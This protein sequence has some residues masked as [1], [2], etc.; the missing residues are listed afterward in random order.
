MELWLITVIIFAC[1]ITFLLLGLPIAFTLSGIGIIFML[2]MKGPAG[3]LMVSSFLYNQGTSFILIAVPL[4]ILMANFLEV[5]DIADD[6]YN[7]MYRWSVRIPGGLASG[8]VIICAIFAAMA[9]ISGVATITM[10]LIAIPSMLK[11]NY[12]KR[13]VT[14]TVAAGGALGILIPPSVIAVLYGSIASASVGKLFMGG[15]I[16]GILL[17]VIF[18]LYITIR[19]IIQPELGPPT[20]ERFTW[21]EK[22][23]SLKAIILPLLMIFTVLST[24]YLGV[25]TPTEAAGIGALGSMVCLIVYRKFTW[26]N[27]RTALLRTFNI[28]CMAVWIVFGAHCFTAVYSMGGAADFMMTLVDGL[29]IPPIGFILIMMLIWMIMGMFLDPVGMLMVT[30]PVF[31]PIV[32]ALGYDPIWFGVLF[33]I[34]CEMAYVTP[35]FG[36]NLFYM[37]AIVPKSITIGDVYASIIPFVICQAV[38]LV[39]VILF[40]EIALWLPEKMMSLGR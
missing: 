27:I 33:I 19:C 37:K 24:I 18:I 21:K 4:F 13:L 14:G 39:L 17:A 10:G 20:D 34:N 5:S 23:A 30:I 36:F 16:P 7:A 11:R 38:C 6:L 31:L 15:V 25:C 3:L 8:T 35:P 28:T 29:A 40:P 32:D 1:L 9:G 22:I 26:E 2:I 12:D